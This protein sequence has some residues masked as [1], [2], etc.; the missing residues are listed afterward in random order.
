[1]ADRCCPTEW[2]PFVIAKRLRLPTVDSWNFS[3][4]RQLTPT[5]SLEAAYVGNH[6]THVFAGTGGDYDPNQP[7]IVGFGTLFREPA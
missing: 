7:T 6:G 5:I 4:Q 1:M 3:V 2:T